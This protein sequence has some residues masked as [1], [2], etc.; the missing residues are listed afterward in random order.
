MARMN[1]E[2]IKRKFLAAILSS[3]LFSGF[4]A[5]GSSTMGNPGVN[6]LLF[7][8]IFFVYSGAIIF[9]YG[10]IV[11]HLLEWLFNRFFQ[12]SK[13]TSLCSI[14]LHGVFGS[15]IGLIGFNLSITIMGFVAALLYGIIDHWIKTRQNHGR[16]LK[17]LTFLVI[18]FFIPSLVLGFFAD[19]VDPFTEEEAQ[20]YVVTLPEYDDFPN[21][22]GKIELTIHGFHVVRENIVKKNEDG[23]YLITLK[24]TGTRGTEK[25]VWEITYRVER[26]ASW[27]EKGQDEVRP[28]FTKEGIEYYLMK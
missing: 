21:T 25:A 17:P 10:N 13:I 14:L 26:G 24:E 6:Y 20:D 2:R 8:V 19:M 11:S 4:M 22:A 7:S 18:A 1:N 15:L 12:P 3:L 9:I 23:T 28:L 5:I 27:L 16:S